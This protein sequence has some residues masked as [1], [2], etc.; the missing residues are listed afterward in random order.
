[1]N[2]IAYSREFYAAQSAGSLASARVV[3]SE[4]FSKVPAK[5]AV[6]VGCGVAPWLRVAID[7]GVEHAVGIDGNYVNPDTLLVD[8]NQFRPCD[9]ESQNLTS[10]IDPGRRFDLAICMEVAEHLSPGRAA[11]FVAELCELSD[12]ILFSAAIPGQGGTNHFNEQWPRYWAALF[13][14]NGFRCLDVLRPRLWEREECEWWYL[15]NVLL[16]AKRNSASLKAASRLRM[17]GTAPPVSLVHP[18][19]VPHVIKYAEERIVEQLATYQPFGRSLDVQLFEQRIEQLRIVAES[20]ENEIQLL[21]DAL[22]QVK[23]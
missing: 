22:R 10:V 15:Q 20:R 23:S 13:G 8:P 5:S 7:L 3:L 9:L 6:D 11:S 21:K 1:M 12:L 19:V 18:R 14:D 4:L 17:T 2:E 16:F